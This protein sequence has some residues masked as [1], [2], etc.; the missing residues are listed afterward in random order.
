MDV[1]STCVLHCATS[2]TNTIFAWTAYQPYM[3]LD[4]PALYPANQPASPSPCI[5]VCWHYCWLNGGGC[6]LI[7]VG[8]LVWCLS[9]IVLVL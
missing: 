2:S 3:G 4:V 1:Q 5:G 8:Y 6:H 9:S 7:L